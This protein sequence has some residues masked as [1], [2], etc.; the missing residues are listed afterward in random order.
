MTV[1]TIGCVFY[2]GFFPENL[3]LSQKTRFVAENRDKLD[4]FGDFGTS[5]MPSG[6]TRPREGVSSGTFLPIIFVQ[7]ELENRARRSL[8]RGYS[9]VA[10]QYSI[11]A[12]C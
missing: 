2:L 8:S 11:A 12:Q 1:A 5:R 4:Y 9:S 10:P 7:W 3:R 6:S